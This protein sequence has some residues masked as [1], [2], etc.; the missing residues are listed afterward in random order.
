MRLLILTGV[1]Q[2]A[3][4]AQFAAAG[5]FTMT[6]W[7]RPVPGYGAVNPVLGPPRTALVAMSVPTVF[8]KLTQPC[9]EEAVT[10]ANN[11]MSGLSVFISFGGAL[12]S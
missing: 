1:V 12:S 2:L 8:W 7:F 6:T 5:H 10:K 9:P 3:D 4:E 11:G